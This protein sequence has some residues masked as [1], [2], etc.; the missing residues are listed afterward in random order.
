[1]KKKVL[2]LIPTRLG[3]V[4]LPAKALLPINNIP[5]II[6]VYKRAKLSKKLDD[7]IICCDDPKIIKVAKK[8]GAKA[9]LTSRHHLNGTERICEGYKLLK[10]KYDFVVDIQGDEPLLSPHHIDDVIEFHL[11]N[12]TSVSKQLT[13]NKKIF[14]ISHYCQTG[15]TALHLIVH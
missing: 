3:S 12:T 4:R 9:L 2:G 8:F 15:I 11:K 5:L 10:K 13:S 6:H 7:V 14:K 1:M